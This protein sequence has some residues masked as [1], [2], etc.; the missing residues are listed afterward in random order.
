MPINYRLMGAA[1]TIVKQATCATPSGYRT[2]L[3]LLKNPK[4]TIDM[5]QALQNGT[6]DIF[7]AGFS[8][9]G[10]TYLTW[11]IQNI[12]PNLSLA[13][14]LHNT[15]SIKVALKQGVPVFV[16]F[17]KPVD[18]ISSLMLKNMHSDKN[19][20]R[21]KSVRKIHNNP[22]LLADLYIREYRHYH[23][24]LLGMKDSLT[25]FKSESLFEA[26]VEI[27][28]I[29]AAAAGIDGSYLSLDQCKD[30]TNAYFSKKRK[31]GLSRPLS[32]GIPTKE[33]A[34]EKKEIEERYLKPHPF[35]CDCCK[36]AA[37]LDEGA[38]RVSD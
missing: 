27:L 1:L 31:Q 30:L 33:K 12:F 28:R 18:S 10:N 7:A 25:L 9:E 22:S 5:L 23:Q 15:V 38:W 2:Y 21:F 17:R 26:P 13:H 35:Y 32:G 37:K 29:I 19:Y 6:I 8:R 34:D 11:L 16:P 14:H 3:R 24:F 20:Y 4:T 36:I